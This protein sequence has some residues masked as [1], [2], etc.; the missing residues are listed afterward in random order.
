MRRSEGRGR[1]TS[2]SL[3]PTSTFLSPLSC[4]RTPHR[5]SGRLR[6]GQRR[7]PSSPQ[8]RAPS[9]FSFFLLSPPNLS[10]SLPSQEPP[11]W[12]ELGPAAA[13]CPAASVSGSRAPASPASGRLPPAPP[14]ASTPASLAGLAAAR[15]RRHG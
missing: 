7:P 6:R 5:A 12:E 1:A 11:P 10:L 9:S 3:S 15:R 13:A 2:S 8:T 4:P 14:R